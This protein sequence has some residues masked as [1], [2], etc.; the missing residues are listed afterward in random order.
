MTNPSFELASPADPG[1]PLG[2]TPGKWGVNDASFE[3]PSEGSDGTPGASVRMTSRTRGDAK[4]ASDPVSV[5]PGVGYVYE[6]SY[7]SSTGTELIVEYGK[8]DGSVSYLF[9]GSVPASDSWTRAQ[10]T[11]TAPSDVRTARVFHILESVGTLSVD[12]AFLST[13]EAPPTDPDNLV[14]NPSVETVS[15]AN[16]SVPLD[17]SKGKWG[18]NSTTFSYPSAAQDGSKGLSIRMRS[19][20]SGDAKWHFKHVPVTAGTEYAYSDYYRSDVRTLVTVQYAHSDGTHSY[21]ELGAAAPTADWIK[22]EKKFVPPAGAVSMSVFHLINAAG[23]LDTDNVR[24]SPAKA[25][26]PPP[27]ADAEAPTISITSPKNG[28]IIGKTTNLTF[29]GSDNVGITSVHYSV[30]NAKDVVVGQL[31]APPYVVSIP[32]EALKNG[33]HVITAH[34]VDAAGNIGNAAPVTY[35]TF[36]VAPPPETPNVVANPSFES[37]TGGM[38]EYWVKGGYGNN[39]ASYNYPVEGVDGGR[40]AEVTVSS[41]TDGDAK[42]FFDDVPVKPGEIYTF[43]DQYK[44]NVASVINLRYLN[45]DGSYTYDGVAKLPA[46]NGWQTY[47]TSISIPAN[48]ER[49]TV[50]HLLAS[51]GTL[52]IDNVRLNLG[53]YGPRDPNAFETGFVSLTF[54]DGWSSHYNT[55]FP[56]LDAAGIKGSFYV[57][58]NEM[59]EDANPNRIKNPSIE[60]SGSGGGSPEFWTAV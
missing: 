6:E 1:T 4:W 54:D 30:S 58:T 8:S 34:A 56:L 45:S 9:L 42:W 53:F 43:S 23:Y 3:Y 47:S 11:F 12:A 13:E 48:A 50:F 17:W 31:T 55:A 25:S 29:S 41:W 60:T 21:V 36:Y 15:P 40:A 33:A 44:S 27:P 39:S 16:A 46:T 19:R 24:M 38:P 14:R 22:Y 2:W 10:K 49:L 32:T 7:K 57:I 5:T 52:A 59:K 28:A 26:E 18:S 20:N 35:Q 51:T 37:M